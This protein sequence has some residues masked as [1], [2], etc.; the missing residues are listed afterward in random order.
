V[1]GAPGAECGSAARAFEEGNLAYAALK[2]D[3]DEWTTHAALGLIGRTEAALAGLA[4]FE[5]LEEARF[6]AAA[7]HWIGGN[8]AEA[9]RL[10]KGVGTEHA[11]NLARLIARPTIE[12]LAQLPWR[13]TP[14]GSL[15]MSAARDPKFRVRNISFQPGDLANEAYADVHRYYGPSD[16][17]AFFICHMV[18]WHYVPPNIQ[19]LPCPIFGQT[20]D[21]DLH[22]QAVYPWLQLFDEVL[23]TDHSEWRDVRRLVGCPVSTFPKSFAAPD[24]LPPIPA[25]TREVDFFLSG[26]TS[27]PYHPDKARLLWQI[28]QIPGLKLRMINGFLNYPE[29]FRELANAKVCCTYCRHLYAMPTRGLEALAMGCALVVEQDS[30]LTLFVGEKEG[31]LTYRYAAG[32]VAAPVRRIVENWDE[33]GPRARRGAAVI[34]EEFN[35]ARVASQYLRY[36]T[37]LA[38][39]PR[40]ARPAGPA[41]SLLQKRPVLQKGWLPSYNFHHN[42][43]LRSIGAQTYDRLRRRT[44]E[45]PA[46]SQA[47]IDLLRESVLYN[48]HMALQESIPRGEWLAA[49]GACFRE[50]LARF[51]RSLVLRFNYIR[52]ALHFGTPAVVQEGLAVLRET[53]ELPAAHWQVDLMEDVFPYD[54]A[55][56]FFNYRRYFD[57]VTE[58]LAGGPTAEE[59]LCRLLLASLY[60]YLGHY[61]DQYQGFY[62][63]DLDA[64]EAASRLDPDFAPY[65]LYYAERLLRTGLP[66]HAAR[67][68]DLLAALAEGS[69]VFL[70]AYELLERAEGALPRLE[71]L[72]PLMRRAREHL[73]SH[74]PL[75]SAP[76]QP[77]VAP[78]P[79]PAPAATNDLAALHQYIAHLH[80]RIRAMEKTKFWKLRK[81]WFRVK[82][83][84][85]LPA[86]E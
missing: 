56:E 17:P 21:Y 83:L 13:R 29:Y 74:E 58:S 52:A 59:E 44:R 46:S 12:V 63:A 49:L 55:E 26:T 85:R 9:L 5:Y 3:P 48:F 10:L 38:A 18:E 69:L 60:F 70:Q 39:R 79:A 36:L 76:L 23:V 75:L 50:G 7:A 32:D 82:R 72:A 28:L 16:V 11:R 8:D 61:S 34:R 35:T 45:G 15:L 30:V 67:A 2:G 86:R 40:G 19:E 57:L 47:Y 6:Y 20:G 80:D 31:V 68:V 53:V 77:V 78:A 66:A 33:F 42:P 22:I 84:L 65:R 4:R 71:G 43:V 25:G 64:F 81:K 1:E 41:A 73:R 51:P 54:F 62:S 14:V 24:G 37:F 27:H